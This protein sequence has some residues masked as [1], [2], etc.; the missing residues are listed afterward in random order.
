MLKGK[1]TFQTPH[2][3]QKGISNFPKDSKSNE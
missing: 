3:D 1:C 2:V